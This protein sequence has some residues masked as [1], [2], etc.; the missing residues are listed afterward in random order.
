MAN[1]MFQ[2][3]VEPLLN[4][5]LFKEKPEIKVPECDFSDCFPTSDDLSE[6]LYSSPSALFDYCYGQYIYPLILGRDF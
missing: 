2:S 6:H 3:N 5:K 1:Q 4:V